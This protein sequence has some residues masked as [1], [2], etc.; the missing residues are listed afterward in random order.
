MCER[1]DESLKR[2]P[3]HPFSNYLITMQSDT[4]RVREKK[5]RILAVITIQERKKKIKKKV[6]SRVYTEA[7]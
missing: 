2:T 6:R 7:I 5:T 4:K 3:R 1:K